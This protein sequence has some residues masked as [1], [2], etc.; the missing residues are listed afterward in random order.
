M[1][2]Y[3]LLIS[4]V[5]RDQGE[6]YVEFLR[7]HDVLT[8]LAGLCRGTASK[9]MLDYLGVEKTEK[10]MLQ[11]MVST[12]L[13]G[14]LLRRMVSQMGIDVPGN[15]IA[16]T[17]P[18]NSV[19]GASSFQYLTRGQQ[20]N[21]NEV[22]KVSEYPYVLL[23][24]IV[25]KGNTDAVMDAARSAGA[26]G[27][28]V[29]NAKGTGA[30]FTEKFFGVSIAAEKEIVYIVAKRADRDAIMHAIMAQSGLDSD[31]HAC[32]FSL[33]VDRIAGLHSIAE[34]EA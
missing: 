14:R 10:M 20:P 2:D 11:T 3:R 34:E 6:A 23:T 31:A 9:S 15:G 13:A 26:K 25:D 28:T 27:G 22:K 21:G 4:I 29:V 12:E 24:V 7:D 18:F 5:R 1:N 19:G 16:M 8:V 32:V 30:E 33:P 17:I